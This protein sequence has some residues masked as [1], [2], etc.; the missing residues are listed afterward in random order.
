M[1]TALTRGVEGF[2]DAV[3]AFF[4]LSLALITALTVLRCLSSLLE[5]LLQSVGSKPAPSVVCDATES[6]SDVPIV[7]GWSPTARRTLSVVD[8]ELCRSQN[9]YQ[10]QN[11]C[12]SQNCC[13]SQNWSHS[14]NQSQIRCQWCQS[15]NRCNQSQNNQCQSQNQSQTRCLKSQN[16]SQTR[17]HQSQN[18]LQPWCH[19]SQN[20]YR[21]SCLLQTI[22]HSQSL[23]RPRPRASD[24]L[25]RTF[26]TG[27]LALQRPADCCRYGHPSMHGDGHHLQ[28][29]ISESTSDVR[30]QTGE[31]QRVQRP[32][33]IKDQ[34]V[35]HK[36]DQT[37]D[38]AAIRREHQREPRKPEQRPDQN[39]DHKPDHRPCQRSDQR[40]DQ[41]PERRTEHRIDQKRGVRFL[42]VPISETI[43]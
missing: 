10:S 17:C 21:C 38:P 14:Q 31:N 9:W 27:S 15:Q 5:Q 40:P 35:D 3:F 28:R 26:S 16:H 37:T 36:L 4:Y 2:F 8:L 20:G 7:T 12:Q 41:R 24:N 6:P 43:V 19:Q 29:T 11:R 25:R 42:T 23:V 1:Q 30:P 18:Q 22:R 33:R 39:S 34:R 13:L 32:D